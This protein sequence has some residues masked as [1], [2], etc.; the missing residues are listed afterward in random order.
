MHGED[1]PLVVAMI[2]AWYAQSQ[3]G[4][5]IGTAINHGRIKTVSLQGLAPWPSG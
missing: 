2:V 1:T 3:V 4:F 5:E